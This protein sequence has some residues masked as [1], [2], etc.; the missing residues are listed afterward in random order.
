MM[1][2]ILDGHQ[3]KGKVNWLNSDKLD[4]LRWA[5][6]Q[7]VV[8]GYPLVVKTTNPKVSHLEYLV[9][10]FNQENAL[11]KWT[12]QVMVSYTVTFVYT[13][14]VQVSASHIPLKNVKINAIR[15]QKNE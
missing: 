12:T 14:T 5:H 8:N 11:T 10:I 6:A 15:S 7:K 13:A 9:N 3:C 1:L 4:R 2:K